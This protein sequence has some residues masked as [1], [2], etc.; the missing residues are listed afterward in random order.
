MSE[1]HHSQ[2]TIF[3]SSH[4]HRYRLW[5]PHSRLSSVYGKFFLSGIS[6]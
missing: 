6:G 5:R 3:F 2:T 4:P 1:F